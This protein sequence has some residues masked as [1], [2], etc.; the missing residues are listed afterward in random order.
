MIVI[1]T[2][3]PEFQPT[4]LGQ[5]HIHSV[6]LNRLP[7]SQ[8]AQ[9]VKGVVDG[10]GASYRDPGADRRENRRCASLLGGG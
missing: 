7:K 4:W 3:R 5:A 10:K 6:M 9:M 1:L 8:S 2:Y